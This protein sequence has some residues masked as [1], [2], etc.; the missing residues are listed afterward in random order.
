MQLHEYL[1][2]ARKNWVLIS[3]VALLGIVLAAAVSFMKAIPAEYEASTMIYVS[4]RDVNNAEG[5]IS[6]DA[7]LNRANID[8]YATIATTES[9]LAPV[10]E[11]FDLEMT[12]ETFRNN[13][14]VAAARAGQSVLEITVNDTVQDRAADLANAVSENLI[15][16][17]E[18]VLEAGGTDASMP[19]VKLTVVENAKMPSAPVGTG[20]LK[21]LA[22]GVLIGA[23][24]GYVIAVL[25]LTVQR[26]RQ[27]ELDSE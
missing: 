18:N 15:D 19:L 11:E 23:V 26:S 5:E 3:V 9:V 21:N 7:G 1:D 24:V 16:V 17:V 25:R 12:T 6:L 20:W 13:H 4:V 27:V 2:V 8:S 14:V 22:A 10:I